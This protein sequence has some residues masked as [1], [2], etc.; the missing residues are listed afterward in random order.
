M[1]RPTLPVPPATAMTDI[2]ICVIL[3]KFIVV[4][5]IKVF[6]I[7]KEDVQRYRVTNEH[8][9]RVHRLY[10]RKGSI[11]FI[12]SSDYCIFHLSAYNIKYFVFQSNQD[13]NNEHL[14][15]LI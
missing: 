3:S 10:T 14:I 13:F 8:D 5:F 2:L 1:V 12:N 9:F 7:G 6:R 15:D 4:L 11:V